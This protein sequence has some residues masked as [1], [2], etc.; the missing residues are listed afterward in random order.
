MKS[1]RGFTLIELL[2]V[3]G[4]IGV[5][6]SIV[7]VNINTARAKGRDSQ[8]VSEMHQIRIALDLFLGANSFYPSPTAPFGD[9]GWE[10]SSV[11]VS[12]WLESL[13][14]YFGNNP[15]PADPVNT[16]ITGDLFGPRSGSY[17]FGYY[18]YDPPAY[19]NCDT[20]SPTCKS[21]TRPIAIL[22]VRN[23]ET[24]VPDDLPLVGMPLPPSI[25]LSRA[26]CGDPGADG[27]CTQA[28]YYAGQCRDWSQEF[29]Y[30]IMFVE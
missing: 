5:L 3:I 26:V 29:D 10:T 30:S 20:G 27:V 25:K 15:T 16:V 1:S 13:A 17:Y 12:Q 18:R 23:M 24:L 7:L 21:V 4:I 11:S 8:R 2:I 22:T 28:E 14:P 9:G 19:C 6:S